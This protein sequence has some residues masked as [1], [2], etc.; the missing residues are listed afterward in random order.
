MM[1][2]RNRLSFWTRLVA[3]VLAVGFLFSS[4][5]I[6]FT[7]TGSYNLL[8][9]FGGQDQGQQQQ[10]QDLG[11]QIQEAEQTLEDNPEDPEAITDLATLYLSDGQ[12]SKGISLL[13]DGMDR[14]PDNADIPLLL[15]QARVQQAQA[16]PE[17]ERDESFRKAGDAFAAA[18]E[19]DSEDADAFLQAGS[20]YDQAGDPGEAIQYYNGYLDLEPDSEQAGQVE[21]RIQSLLDEGGS[22]GPGGGTSGGGGSGG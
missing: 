2:D 5:I 21:D 11:P 18:T 16:Q 8:E 22:G 6:G 19:R 20:A 17:G 1:M 7:A 10:S 3:I 14:A 12:S 13:E 9:V 15:G 4:V